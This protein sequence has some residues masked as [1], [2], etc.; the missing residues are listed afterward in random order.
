MLI[1]DIIQYLNIIAPPEQK[2]DWDN[3]GLIVGNS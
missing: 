1:K 2:E 3:I